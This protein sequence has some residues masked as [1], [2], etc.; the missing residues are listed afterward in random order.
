M[1]PLHTWLR[2]R[3][4]ASGDDRGAVLIY[5]LVFIT[6]IAIVVAAV[7]SLADTN[8]RTT[9]ALRDQA[10]ETAGADGAAQLAINDLRSGSYI[11][12]TGSCFATPTLELTN[13]YQ[14]PDGPSLS[15]RVECAQDD[16]LSVRPGATGAGFALLTLPIGSQE[17]L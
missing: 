3:I 5:A 16:G 2:R 14:P 7:I 8:L 9:A 10:G 1:R 17:G 13:F 12:P 11:G 15:A 6:V 4:H